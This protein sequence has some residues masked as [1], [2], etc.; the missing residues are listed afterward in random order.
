MKLIIKDSQN[1][2]TSDFLN[3][4]LDQIKS[5][6]L[7][8][9]DKNKLKTFDIYLNNSNLFKLTFISNYS[10]EKLLKTCLDNLIISK[11]NQVITIQFDNNV[12]LFGL[13][14]TSVETFCKFINYGNVNIKGYPIFTN[15]FN[16]IITNFKDYVDFYYSIN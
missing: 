2:L 12:L 6:L 7:I 9:L 8:S 11:L 3:W 1:L 4:L 14:L 16:D 5:K 13:T 15:C 10:T